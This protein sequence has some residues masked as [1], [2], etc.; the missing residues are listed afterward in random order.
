LTLRNSITAT[1]GYS[2]DC[3][4]LA[5]YYIN[6]RFLQRQSVLSADLYCVPCA[7]EKRSRQL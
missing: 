4:S 5:A 1:E 2:V 6:K 7:L 3:N